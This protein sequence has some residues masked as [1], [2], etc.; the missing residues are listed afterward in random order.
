MLG[1]IEYDCAGGGREADKHCNVP[2]LHG[3]ADGVT[4]G[5]IPDGPLAQGSW[6]FANAINISI[7]IIIFCD[8]YTIL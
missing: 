1:R 3:G 5:Q 4:E 7:P 6:A 2:A 8:V